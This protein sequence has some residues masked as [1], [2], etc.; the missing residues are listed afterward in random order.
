LAAAA[1]DLNDR[2]LRPRQISD[3]T[4]KKQLST[5]FVSMVCVRG[6]ELRGF[7]WNAEASSKL[8]TPGKKT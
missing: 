8:S 6:V 4:P 3:L 7:P 5:I 2:P 1:G